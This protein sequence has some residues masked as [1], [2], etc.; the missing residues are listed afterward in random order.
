MRKYCVAEA[1]WQK[2]CPYIHMWE[3]PNCRCHMQARNIT[4]RSPHVVGENVVWV[5]GGSNSNPSQS[6]RVAGVTRESAQALRGKFADVGTITVSESHSISTLGTHPPVFARPP[7]GQM[8]GC[9]G[10]MVLLQQWSFNDTAGVV[11]MAY[12]NAKEAQMARR[13]FHR[14]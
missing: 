5:G 11:H 13:T 4:T 3:D 14:R 10:L 8:P 7:C 9:A 1:M 2:R 12:A 6:L